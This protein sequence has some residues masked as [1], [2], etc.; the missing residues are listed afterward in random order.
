VDS[1]ID[2]KTQTCRV[3]AEVKNRESLDTKRRC[4]MAAGAEDLGPQPAGKAEVGQPNG[5]GENGD[6]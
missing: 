5:C 2:V 6:K 1:E 4:S 3:V